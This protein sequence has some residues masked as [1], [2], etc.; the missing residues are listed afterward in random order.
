MTPSIPILMYHQ[1]AR[2]PLEAFCRYTVTAR[3]FA[4]QMRWLRGNGY[5]TVDPQRLVDWRAGRA[6]LPPRPV[7]ITFDDGFRDSLGHALPVLDRLG[8]TAIFYLP[9][10]LIGQTSRWDREEVG[11]E[12]PLLD[13]SDARALEAAGLHCGAHG[14]THSRLATL[15]A[16]ACLQELVEAR[17][18]LEERLGH[19][20]TH[21]AYPFGSTDERVRA[22]VA[23]AGY[24][25]ACSTRV[26]LA[27]F[28]ADL[29]ALPR[30]PVLGQDSL[31]D[32]ACRLRTGLT[33]RQ[34]L[35]KRLDALR[36]RLG[37]PRAGRSP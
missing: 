30:V 5:A 26:G 1:L 24:T 3:A 13:W 12:M 33:L 16:S 21:M 17:R 27:S 20:V 10:G 37:R 8:L 31:A 19:D 14:L 15:S 23:E 11:L 2:Q 36:A 32:F 9:A 7:M 25:S 22:M 4:A 28:D 29:L 34:I 6:S 35:R 18:L